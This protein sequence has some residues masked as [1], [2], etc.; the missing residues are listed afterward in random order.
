MLEHSGTL[1]HGLRR[2]GLDDVFDALWPLTCDPDLRQA[3]EWLGCPWGHAVASTPV[4]DHRLRA[5]LAAP[6]RRHLRP[7]GA[8]A[9]AR[10]LP[11]GDGAAQPPRRGL[12]VRQ[13][14]QRLRLPMA[15]GPG[16]HRRA[17]RRPVA[18]RYLPHRLRC[19]SSGGDTAEIVAV[20]KTQG[21]DTKLVAQMQPYYEAKGLS[22]LSWPAT[23][24]ATAGHAGRRRRERRGDDERVSPQVPR[25]RR[26]APA[27]RTP[28]LNVTKYL[29]QLFATGIQPGD[30][31]RPSSRCT[32]TASGSSWHAATADRL[33]DVIE[34]LRREDSRFHVEGGSWTSDLSWVR[35]YDQVLVPMEQASALFHER[36]LARGV[37][38]DDPRYRKG[39]VPPAGGRDELLPLLGAG[40]L[41][42]LRRRAIRRVAEGSSAHDR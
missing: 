30:P 28:I 21:S 41:D 12:C 42:R 27:P 24:G 36:I 16:I 31:Y 5:G 14:P 2:A 8:G 33:A 20:V 7:G 18:G 9:G 3:V 19:T 23:W 15:A 29:E 6:L 40:G 25:G 22:R 39:P 35:G 37:P 1:L 10:L 26:S 32:S 34:Q 13:D 17:A 11:G 38:S 4:Q